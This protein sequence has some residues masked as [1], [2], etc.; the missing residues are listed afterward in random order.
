[1]R[2]AQFGELLTPLGLIA[3]EE[4]N[5]VRIRRANH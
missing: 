2:R 5:V 3:A 1:L 4:G